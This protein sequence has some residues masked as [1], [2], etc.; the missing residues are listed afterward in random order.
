MA[1]PGIGRQ[2]GAKAPPC[3]IVIFGATGDLTARLLMPAIYNL[4]RTG[5]LSDNFALIGLGR[6]SQSDTDFRKALTDDIQRF[7]AGGGEGSAGTSFDAKAWDFIASRTTY[8]SGDLT[9]SDT[10]E[11]LKQKLDEV[12]AAD[13]TRGN[14]LFYLAVAASLFGPIIDRLGAAGLTDEQDGSWRRVI[15]EKP[16]GTDLASAKA[17]NAQVLKVLKES[18]IYR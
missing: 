17:L 3:T 9:K 12:S 4:S 11:S 2:R 14:V 6:T 18:Q 8:M 10:Y 1:E 5:L 16:F 13:G 15:I 7:V